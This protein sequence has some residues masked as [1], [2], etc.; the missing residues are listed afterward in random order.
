MGMGSKT[1]F[2]IHTSKS[3]GTMTPAAVVR[4]FKNE[5]YDIIA[6]TDHDGIDGVREAKI[7][8][9]AMELTVISGVEF[10]TC[11]RLEK[12]IEWGVDFPFTLPK[13]RKL[14]E[15][16]ENG[17]VHDTGY[18]LDLH[19]LGY[20]FDIDNAELNR[21]TGLLKE[22]RYER[23]LKLIEAL[24]EAGYEMTYEE[25]LAGKAGD[26]V[27]KPV[28][29]RYMAE[30]GYLKEAAEAF[31]KGLFDTPEM[32]QVNRR[33]LD[34]VSAME[35]IKQAGGIS[36]M[37][38]PMKLKGIGERGSDLFW[39]NLDGLIFGLKKNGLKGLECAHS[40]HTREEMLKLVD[41]AEKYHLHITKGSDFH[42]DGVM[43][44]ENLKI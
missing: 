15:V 17:I 4:K 24:N 6:I 8:G 41:L 37:A 1:D 18:E 25:I 26:Y 2:H 9:E 23:N 33:K 43:G 14:P 39:H 3:D 30:K 29:A 22:Y 7:A 20:Y 13:N 5:E 28:I 31:S 16:D 21:I 35:L 12:A 10:A 42:G 19:L 40:N 36:V 32:K 44:E 38:H 34:V 27:G 11:V